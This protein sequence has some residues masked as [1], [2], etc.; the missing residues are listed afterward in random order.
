MAITAYH[1]GC[2][3]WGYK[4]WVGVLYRPGTPARD[5]LAQYAS[6][7]NT[8]E[9]NTTFYSVPSAATVTRWLDQV[10]PHFRFCFKLPRRISHEL[11]LIQAEA[12]TT[13]F[14]H[15]M[16]PLGERL[17]PFMIQLPPAFGPDRLAVLDDYLATLPHEL[18]F[19]VEVRHRRFFDDGDVAARLDDLLV[20]HGCERVILD[21][22]PLRSGDRNHPEVKVY[23]HR[24]PDLPVRPFALGPYPLLRFI[25]H[26][27]VA[28][29]IPW[30]ETWAS[31]LW[32]WIAEGRQPYAF[33]HCPN[34]FHAPALARRL[35]T[36]LASHGNV[37][38]MPPW[39][40][41]RDG[42]EAGQLSL[43]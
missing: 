5:F 17:G 42:D 8:V 7:F 24:K 26:P 1:L 14:L 20:R 16:A 41:E 37:G 15:R 34:D 28:V 2:P 9:G 11:G 32:D 21:T 25:G 31:T 18:H 36:Q 13:Q 35:H 27:E 23:R 43:L 10:P 29:N 4:D 3:A 19:A 38:Q 33:L 40:A 22:R 12:E 39:P 6:V 30:I